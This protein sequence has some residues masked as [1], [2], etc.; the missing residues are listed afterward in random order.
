V[1][2]PRH[3]CEAHNLGRGCKEKGKHHK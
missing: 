3:K 1:C 2:H